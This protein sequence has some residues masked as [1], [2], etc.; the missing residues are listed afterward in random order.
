MQDWSFMNRCLKKKQEATER[1]QTKM[2]VLSV[3]SMKGTTL[4]NS[5]KKP[6]GYSATRWKGTPGVPTKSTRKRLHLL[7]NAPQLP[8]RLCS[9]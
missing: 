2:F 9:K 5:L 6:V 8:K 7:A 1:N 4:I 3:C